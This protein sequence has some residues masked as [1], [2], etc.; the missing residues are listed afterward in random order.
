MN[1]MPEVGSAF[2]RDRDG[3]ALVLCDRAQPQLAVTR[4]EQYSLMQFDGGSTG[5]QFSQSTQCFGQLFPV[6]FIFNSFYMWLSF[7]PS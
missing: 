6:I 5:D 1:G 3:K 7:V 4:F 2:R